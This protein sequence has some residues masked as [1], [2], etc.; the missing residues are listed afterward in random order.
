MLL[1]SPMSS[2]AHF[3]VLVIPAFCLGRAALRLRSATL[4]TALALA[5]LLGF[6]SIK[7]PLGERLYTLALWCGATTWQTLALLAGCLL[8][9]RW[10]DA[11]ARVRAR[12][13]QE[14]ELA[15]AA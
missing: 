14:E 2:K 10:T 7:D 4:W 9:V 13:Q 8:G 15:V 12:R 6:T 3:G 1:L 11:A 5:V